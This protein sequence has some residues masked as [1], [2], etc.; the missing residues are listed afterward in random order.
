MSSNEMRKLIDLV[1]S[2]NA[3]LLESDPIMQ[4]SLNGKKITVGDNYVTLSNPEIDSDSEHNDFV[5]YD[6]DLD[7]QDILDKVESYQGYESS[8]EINDFFRNLIS[9][10]EGGDK[11]EVTYFPRE[12]IWYMD[13]IVLGNVHE[14]EDRDLRKILSH[15]ISGV[16]GRFEREMEEMLDPGNRETHDDHP[17][18]TAAERNR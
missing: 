13:D 16:S 2:A 11:P 18:L 17:S 12:R 15:V 6:V 4:G 5:S 10:E 7:Y 8:D 9:T 3:K 1:E 14:H